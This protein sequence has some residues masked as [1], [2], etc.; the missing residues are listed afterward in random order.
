MNFNHLGLRKLI[1]TCYVNSPIAKSQLTLDDIFEKRKSHL[2]PENTKKPYKIVINEVKDLNGNG[3]TGLPDVELLIKN[4]EN[5]LTFLKGDG[6]FRSKEL[7]DLLKESDIVV[8]N[9]PFSLFRQYV[10]QLMDYNKKFII[11]G[12]QNA[13][14]Y[15]EL[16]PYIMHNKMW[17]G[18]SIHSGDREFRVPDSYPLDA[19]S[20]RIDKDGNK[21]IR[22]KGIRWFTNLDYG[23]RH[24]DLV[25]YK[26]YNE[27]EYP[28]YDNYDAINVNVTTEIPYNYYGVMGVPITFLDKYNP[29]QFEIVG[30]SQKYGFG[31]ESNKIYDEYKEIRQD[32]TYTGSSG[33][34]TNGN[35]VMAG[36][37]AKGNYYT[38]GTNCVYSLYSRIFIK[39]RSGEW[40]SN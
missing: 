1:A 23:E 36:K 24:E 29:D 6:D 35:P 14:S 7:I 21:Y 39:R 15:K 34:R 4:S 12:N 3:T 18:Q 37:P 26:S 38:N 28:K 9:P 5:T 33:K 20:Y 22:V 8:T 32:G 10:K 40:T 17:L 13:I 30:L 25:L 31:L 11:L 27:K 2:T 16:F 19:A